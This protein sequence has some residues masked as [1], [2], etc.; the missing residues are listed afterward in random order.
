MYRLGDSGPDGR[1]FPLTTIQCK[2]TVSIQE[3]SIPP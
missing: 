2:Y 3:E 1:N